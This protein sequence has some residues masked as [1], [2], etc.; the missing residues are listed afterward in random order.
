MVEDL[1]TV[2]ERPITLSAKEGQNYKEYYLVTVG[3]EQK[4]RMKQR[5]AEVE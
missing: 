2:F 4:V 1:E 5:E 3:L